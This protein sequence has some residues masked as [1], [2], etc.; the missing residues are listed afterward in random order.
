MLESDSNF[1]I[2]LSLI[3][4][5]DLEI[6]MFKADVSKK[7][8]EK[9]GEPT[10][11]CFLCWRN[12]GIHSGSVSD[13]ENIRPWAFCLNKEEYQKSLRRDNEIRFQIYPG[14][15]KIVTAGSGHEYVKVLSD[16]KMLTAENICGT[17]ILRKTHDKSADLYPI[18]VDVKM[19]NFDVKDPSKV[20]KHTFCIE[21]VELQN[22]TKDFEM[23]SK[24]FEKTD[25]GDRGDTIVET[26][27]D[28]DIF[29]DELDDAIPF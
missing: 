11:E 14:S 5:Q 13:K 23:Y 6:K 22:P 2:L 20:Y 24:K 8:K 4:L 3:M 29:G 1:L 19:K 26:I 12:G 18:F 17:A 25:A 28:A 10:D 9:L 15:F 21:K 27:S 16:K 7:D